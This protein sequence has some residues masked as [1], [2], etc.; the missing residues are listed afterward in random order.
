MLF[1]WSVEIKECI[2]FIQRIIFKRIRIFLSVADISEGT[3]SFYIEIL[4]SLQI[5][6]K[7]WDF[8]K[9]YQISSIESTL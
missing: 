2:F 1:S 8:P 6:V 3:E 9:L 7:I 5:F 4:N